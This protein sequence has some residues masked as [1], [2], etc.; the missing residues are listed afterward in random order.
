M[1]LK[2]TNNTSYHEGGSQMSD[3][4]IT[5]NIGADCRELPQTQ[6][7]IDH[8]AHCT[9]D[10][11]CMRAESICQDNLN[12]CAEAQQPSGGMKK[13]RNKLTPILANCAVLLAI[14]GLSGAFAQARDIE[15]TDTIKN[16]V[17]VETSHPDVAGNDIVINDVH[18]AGTIIAHAVLE[19]TDI[20]PIDTGIE[21][22]KKIES[23]NLNNQID[24]SII[25]VENRTI[26][27]DGIVSPIELADAVHIEAI[28]AVD[29]SI[30]PAI[31]G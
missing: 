5:G 9:C 6:E 28:S 24:E 8:E 15:S 16:N 4:D 25:A 27:V 14:L 23:V 3:S 20:K 7:M 13:M 21:E 31:R 30:L 17:A 11:C 26:D 29:T 10:G 2:K 18:D 12:Q 22:G 1:K 19:I